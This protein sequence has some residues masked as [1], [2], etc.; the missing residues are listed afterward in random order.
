MR[1]R[2]CGP[3]PLIA[4]PQTL[5]EGDALNPL[6]DLKSCHGQIARRIYPIQAQPAFS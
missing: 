3:D 2:P 1:S 5:P 4:V 6:A